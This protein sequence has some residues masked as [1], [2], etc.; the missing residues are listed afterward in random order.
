MSAPRSTTRPGIALLTALVVVL[1]LTMFLSELFFATGMELR[2]LESFKDSSQARRLARSVLKATE[3]GLLQDEAEFF[4]GYRQ[5]QQVMTLSSVPIESGRLVVLNI[6]PA[7]SLFNVNDI[8]GIREGTPQDMAKFIVFQNLMA[9]I[10]VPAQDAGN[11]PAPPQ[12]A[13][14]S[15]IYASLVDWLDSDDA[16]YTAP[17]GVRGAEAP[18][19]IGQNPEYVPKNTVLD[20]LEEMR[21]VLGFQEARIPWREIEKRFIARPRSGKVELYSEKVNANVAT[22]EEI[23]NFLLA[24]RVEE[25]KVLSDGQNGTVQKEL[26]KYADFARD[27]AV[28]LVP[29]GQAR[30]VYSDALIKTTLNAVGVNGNVANQVFSSISQYYRIVITTEVGDIQATITALVYANRNASDRTA[31]SVEVQQFFFN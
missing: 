20:R 23:E 5:L 14:V 29:D 2:A 21:L 18:A 30:P 26:N 31:K 27:I 10:L 16:V 6:V 25:S 12:E 17:D 7:D 28:A 22:R 19:Y 9:Q 15:Q 4:N 24:H 3:I 13:Q 8:A 1:L 11:P